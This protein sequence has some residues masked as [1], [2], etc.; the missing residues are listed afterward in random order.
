MGNESD[1]KGRPVKFCHPCKFHR[2][3]LQKRKADPDKLDEKSKELR[4]R[5]KTENR[6]RQR[7]SLKVIH[8]IDLIVI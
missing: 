2:I 5:L 6:R 4:K 8:K 3:R 1:Q 7:T